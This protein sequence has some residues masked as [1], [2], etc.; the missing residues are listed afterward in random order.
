MAIIGIGGM[1]KKYATIIDKGLVG[2]MTLAAVTCRSDEN[3]KW[4]EENL[5]KETKIIRDSDKL[6]DQSDLFDAVLIVTPHKTH[7]RLAIQAF[8]HGKHVF[9]DK[10]AGVSLLQS[11]FMNEAAKASGKKYAMMFHQRLFEKHIRIKEILDNKEI[12]DIRRVMLENSTYYRTKYYHKSGNWRSSW[13]GEGGGVLI[14][15]GQHILDIWLWLFG[16]PETVSANI[17]FGKYNDFKVEDE[18]TIYM[19]YPND[20]SAVFMITTGEPVR[21]ER[22]EIVGT[23]GKLLLEDNHL[24]IWRFE[25]DIKDYSDTAVVTDA[26]DLKIDLIEEELEAKPAP[27]REMLQNFADS[28]LKDEKLVVTGEE[29]S[30]TLEITNAAYLSAWN[31][32]T[33][34]LPID[35][36]EYEMQLEIKMKEE[37]L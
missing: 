10:P 31:N 3:V 5:S 20:M 13:N 19:Q 36:R 34:Q 4:A 2:N 1:G 8:E 37:M 27:Y 11:Q 30:N 32:K 14:N 25:E 18:A 22:L 21:E 12:G 7:P 23:K 24:K 16:M 17:G 15:Q 28:I 33:I 6:Y 29:G 26:K 35:S 9:C